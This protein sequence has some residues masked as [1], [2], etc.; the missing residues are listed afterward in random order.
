MRGSAD[1]KRWKRHLIQIKNLK[2]GENVV[3]SYRI[4]ILDFLKLIISIH[5]ENF[6]LKFHFSTYCVTSI[7]MRNAAVCHYK[8]HHL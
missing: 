1:A 3:Q 5:S 6:E 4:F 7:F 2:Y 8:L